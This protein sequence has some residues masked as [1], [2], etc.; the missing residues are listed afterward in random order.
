MLITLIPIETY[1]TTVFF[2]PTNVYR[3]SLGTRAIES[4]CNDSNLHHMKND[5]FS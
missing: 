5:L 2:W 4:Q 1:N 3:G